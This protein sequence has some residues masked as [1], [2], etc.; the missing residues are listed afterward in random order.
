MYIHSVT[1]EWHCGIAQCALSLLITTRTVTTVSL[2]AIRLL[3]D[4][5]VLHCVIY[6]RRL[7]CH[8]QQLYGAWLAEGAKALKPT[9]AA[10][11][12]YLLL[13]GLLF[14]I[15]C[16]FFMYLSWNYFLVMF[17]MINRISCHLRVLLIFCRL[18]V[19][20][21]LQIAQKHKPLC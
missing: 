10:N 1:D 6:A 16:P 11:Y 5:S 4:K 21:F 15:Y 3:D 19:H 8:S 9:C 14:C 20:V 7:W 2:C 18:L 13:Q 17:H 12:C